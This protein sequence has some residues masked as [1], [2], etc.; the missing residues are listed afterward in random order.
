MLV[1]FPDSCLFLRFDGK[2]LTFSSRCEFHNV[3]TLVF[4]FH[5]FL[6]YL[7]NFFVT[8]LLCKYALGNL[9]SSNTMLQLINFQ[10]GTE[11]KDLQVAIFC[12]AIKSLM[13]KTCNYQLSLI[14]LACASF[15]IIHAACQQSMS[16]AKFDLSVLFCA[17]FHL[18]EAIMSFLLSW[19]D[20]S[21]ALPQT[22][23]F[24]SYAR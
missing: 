10:N 17:L 11:N 9:C 20:T 23:V 7:F 21:A 8:H 1:R 2:F 12:H 22:L 14:N 6:R 18:A 5:L 4:N 16:T 13:L 15:K 24:H 3:I 19:N